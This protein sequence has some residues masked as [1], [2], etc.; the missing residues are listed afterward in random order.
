MAAAADELVPELGDRVTILS[1]VHKRTTGRIVYRD[2]SL[3]RVRPETRATTAVDF[4]LDPDTQMFRMDLGVN[5]VQIHEKRKS[6]AYAAQLNVYPEDRLVFYSAIGEPVGEPGIVDQVIATD[7]QD[8]IVLQ[9]G[10]VLD[11]GFVGPQEPLALLIPESIEDDFDKLSVHSANTAETAETDTAETRESQREIPAWE[12]EALGYEPEAVAD[13]RTYDDVAQREDMFLSMLQ[14]VSYKQQKN[15]NLMS[16]LYRETDLLTALKNAIVVRD[17]DQAIIPGRTRSYIAR[18]LREVVAKEPMPLSTLVPVAAVKKVLYTDSEGDEEREDVLLLNDTDSLLQGL[19]AINAYSEG[20]GENA[21]ATYIQALN[22]S[23]RVFSPLSLEG[24]A[25]AK[26]QVDQD[27]FRTKPPGK[28][29]TGFPFNEQA[30]PGYKVD[31]FGRPKGMIKMFGDALFRFYQPAELTRILAGSYVA[32]PKTGISFMV[33]E[34]DTSETVCHVLLSKSLAKLRLPV[35]SSVLLWDIVASES[36]RSQRTPFSEHY[37]VDRPGQRVVTAD[38]DFVVTELLKERIRPSTSFVNRDTVGVLDSLG[39]RSLEMTNAMLAAVQ[40]GAAQQAWRLADQGRKERAKEAQVPSHPPLGL[41]VA[42]ESPLVDAQKEELLK[43]YVDETNSF[44]TAATLSESV[45]CTLLPLWMATANHAKSD[46]IDPLQAAATAELRRQTLFLDTIRHKEAALQGRPKINPCKHVHEVERIK[47]IKDTNKRTDM[48]ENYIQTM[49][50]GQAGHWVLC[51][52]CKLPLVCKHEVLMIQEVRHPGKG[53]V[54]HK[55]LILDY[56]SPHVFEGSYICKFCGQPIQRLEYDTNLEFDDDGIPLSGRAVLEKDPD[57]EDGDDNT[58]TVA[59]MEQDVRFTGAD[60]VLYGICRTVLERCGITG[61]DEMYDGMIRSA[62]DYLRERVPDETYYNGRRAAAVKAAE[63]A[64]KAAAEGKKVAAVRVPPDYRKYVANFQVAV[65]A[66]LTLFEL[67]TAVRSVPFPAPGCVFATD[68]FPLDSDNPEAG[69]GALTYV[70]CVV[71]GIYRTDMPWKATSWS[72]E[73]D[74]SKRRQGVIASIQSAALTLLGLP[75]LPPLTTVTDSYKERF[76]KKREER[77]KEGVAVLPSRGDVLPSA[78]RPMPFY[79]PM[80]SDAVG[81]E[82]GFLRNVASRPFDEVERFVNV[83]GKALSHTVLKEFNALA[84]KS[85]PRFIMRSEGTCCATPLQEALEHGVG[86]AAL[87][88]SAPVRRELAVLGG[89]GLEKRDTAASA[90]GTH[91]VV[92]WSAP[93]MANPLPALQ[94]DLYYKLFLKKCAKGRRTGLTHEYNTKADGLV[95]RHCEFVLPRAT[96]YLNFSEIVVS[97]VK[98]GEVKQV[99]DKD[100]EAKLGD[101]EEQRKALAL[102][103]FEEQHIAINDATFKALESAVKRRGVL[104]PPMP[105]PDVD[106]LARLAALQP[107]LFPILLPEARATW[108]LML[109]TLGSIRGRPV[110]VQRAQEWAK[111]SGPTD[112]TFRR[113]EA[114]LV[115]LNEE[116]Q[117]HEVF[118]AVDALFRDLLEEPIKLYPVPPLLER[119]IGIAKQPV[120]GAHT[121]LHHLVTLGEKTLSEKSD[122]TISLLDFFTTKLPLDKFFHSVNREHLVILDKIWS[123]EKLIT[124]PYGFYLGRSKFVKKGRRRGRRG[125]GGAVA[126]AA[127]AAAANR[128]EEE[129][130][131]VA[132]P[133][134]GAEAAEAAEAAAAGK[135]Y[136][137]VAREAE[138]NALDRFTAALGPVL[139]QFVLEFRPS[140]AVTEREWATILCF[141]TISAIE[142]LLHESSPV[143]GDVDSLTK[144]E[145]ATIFFA[146]YL[147]EVLHA[148]NT[149]TDR[150]ERSPDE[151]RRTL[152]IREEI[153]KSLFTRRF[154]TLDK[155]RRDVVNVEKQLKLGD[156][157]QGKLENLVNYRSATVGFQLGQIRDLGIDDFGVHVGGEQVRPETAA[158]RNG[159]NALAPVTAAEGGYNNRAAQD[160]DA[161]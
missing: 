45:G 67:Q 110:G 142:S 88:L 32:D 96:Q 156:W 31:R 121:L 150:Y 50:A 119:L 34:P 99:K 117:E 143:Y 63:E 65:V 57:D 128:E 95:C 46:V 18:T 49:G 51:G 33:A 132:V 134:G 2:G 154:E 56:A 100:I 118:G 38:Q 13:T 24:A 52:L 47:N 61:S 29:I 151:I 36:L 25:G 138:R 58:D 16:R 122:K 109:E 161:L 39:L 22:A 72:G 148:A 64:K 116:L 90:N 140:A 21:F 94:P 20:T 12:A 136:E 115:S 106:V 59:L 6:P 112:E 8:A 149:F 11:F 84:S 160:E 54:L 43:D 85:V 125:G 68:G 145:D 37:A 93:R 55:T 15:P 133:V 73:T 23:H 124:R 74:L 70:G 123:Q 91:I 157:A 86:V 4:P 48:L 26:T 129:E 107:V 77:G 82:E 19:R 27:V 103:A 17:A 137:H 1:D 79:K 153:E 7:T 75:T 159:F 108:T 87:P 80:P 28:L 113:V 131:E 69:K 42:V 98:D 111:V 60:K 44:Q 127:A 97:L 135:R 130:E 101:Q 35:R 83:R 71:A 92:P 3:I 158:E 78:F 141:V 144:K 155:S 40:T 146:M 5:E 114:R 120:L 147:G 30:R 9:D 105:L 104:Q 89:S 139:S 10:R 62:N 102:A 66:A 76:A 41:L 152:R 14:S 81:S 53:K 126:V